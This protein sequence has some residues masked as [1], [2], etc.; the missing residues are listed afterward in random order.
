MI[1]EVLRCCMSLIIM[2]RLLLQCRRCIS[3]VGD[4]YTSAWL[5]VTWQLRL[6]LGEFPECGGRREESD[7]SAPIPPF[8]FPTMAQKFL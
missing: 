7:R 1:N 2:T 8:F 3:H 5:V 6:I 4:L